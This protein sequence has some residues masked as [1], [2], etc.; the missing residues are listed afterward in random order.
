MV[1]HGISTGALFLLVG[2]LYERRHTRE[3]QAF[4]GIAR[5]MPAFSAFFLIATFS[6]IGLPLLNGFVGELLILLG[7][8]GPNPGFTVLAASGVV[9]GAAYMLWMVRRV[10][11][12]PLVQE[13]NRRLSDLGA[14]ELVV[15]VA[16]T[17]PML[18]IGLYP[19]TFLRPMDRSVAELLATLER[20]GV[21]L[22]AYAGR[23]PAEP[24]QPAGTGE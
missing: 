11:F 21:D 15:A 4:G 18:W 9:L 24:A 13:A 23:A 12:G 6:S 2:M 14:R 22:A 3:I 16:I 1:N 8:F 19:A 20:R 17:I 10:F 7:S 5:A